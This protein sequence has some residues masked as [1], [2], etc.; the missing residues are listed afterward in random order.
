MTS[1]FQSSVKHL[2]RLMSLKHPPSGYP[3]LLD[4]PHPT[5]CRNIAKHPLLRDPFEEKLCEV[6][7]PKIYLLTIFDTGW[8]IT[9]ATRG[10]RSFCQEGSCGEGSCISLQWDQSEVR[11]LC[12]RAPAQVGHPIKQRSRS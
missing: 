7:V 11:H 1:S 12:R 4:H 10:R 8:R 3:N 6:N 2:A 5:V 9:L